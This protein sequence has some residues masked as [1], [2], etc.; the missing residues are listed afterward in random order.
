V[1]TPWIA[2]RFGWS[3]GLSFA[4]A[5]VLLGVLTWLFVDPERKILP[6]TA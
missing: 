2:S 6:A 5:L 4:S 1:V 3:G